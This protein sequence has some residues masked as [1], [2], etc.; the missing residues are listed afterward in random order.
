MGHLAPPLVITEID[1]EH[2]DPRHL[3]ALVALGRSIRA[4]TRPHDT[5]PTEEHI[6]RA[7][8]GVAAQGNFDVRVAVAWRDGVAA[9]DVTT[10]SSRK[11]DN[12]HVLQVEAYVMPV[13]RRR[14]VGTRLLEVAIQRARAEGRTLLIGTTTESVA[15]GEPFARRLGARPG[16]VSLVYEA[17]LGELDAALLE[18]WVC[19]GPQRA[20]DVEV[21]WLG[22]PYPEDQLPSLATVMR[23]MNDVPLGDLQVGDRTVTPATLRDLDDMQRARG[24]ERWTLVAQHRTSGTIVGATETLWNSANPAVLVQLGTVVLREA[25]GRGLGRWLKAAMLERV[26]RERPE[27]RVV[28]TDNASMN[29]PMQAIN[30]ALGFR[31][32]L[33]ETVWQV[34]TDVAAAALGIA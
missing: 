25:R 9:G 27:A 12:A 29:A 17:A 32:A 16:L 30:E 7:L 28:R 22:S 34:E 10:A 14:G 2:P 5:A 21:V 3:A 20:P 19:A 11:G 26:V 31:V 8:A 13:E 18:A 6:R 4:E 23:A 33:T 15:A 1:R 24:D